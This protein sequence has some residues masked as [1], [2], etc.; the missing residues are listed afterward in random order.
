METRIKNFLI[1][2]FL[3]FLTLRLMAKDLIDDLLKQAAPVAAVSIELKS[4]RLRYV[5]R[6]RVAITATW[7]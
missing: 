3:A 1:G 5:I 4:G 2:L 6:V 7:T